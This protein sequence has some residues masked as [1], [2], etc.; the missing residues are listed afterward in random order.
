MIK[1]YRIGLIFSETGSYSALGRAMH[2]GARLAI[3]EVNADPKLSIRLEPVMRDPGGDIAAYYGAVMDL[4]GAEKITHVVGCYTSSSRKEVLPL[5]EKHDGLLWYPSH[6]EGFETS[7]NVIYVGASPNQHVIPLLRYLL[8]WHGSRVWCVGSNYIWAWENNRIVREALGRMG[9]DVMAERYCRV[10]ETDL[11]EL[12]AQ[13]VNDRP[14]VVFCTLIGESLYRFL[15]L[16]RA[17][18]TAAGIDQARDMPVASCSL[19]EAEL[20]AIATARSGHLSASVYFS[21]IETPA[22][23]RF[24]AKWQER[25]GYLGAA[26]ADAEAGYNAVHLLANAIHKAGSAELTPV[27]DAARGMTFDAPQGPITLDTRNLHC[28]MRPRIGLSQDDGTFRIL[29]EEAANVRPD[30]FLVWTEPLTAKD[31]PAPLRLRVVR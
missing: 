30:P 29:Y 8:R 23:A 18:A 4:L 10:G 16:F 17:A 3:E 12:V 11:Q 24:C 28:A 13:I 14:D 15:D 22:N 27:R 20:P 21:T 5:F 26:C 31:V 25:F 6:Y 7:D 2:A 19:S 9:I 1:S